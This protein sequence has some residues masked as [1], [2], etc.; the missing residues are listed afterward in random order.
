[1]TSDITYDNPDQQGDALELLLRVRV[2]GV[3]AEGVIAVGNLRIVPTPEEDAENRRRGAAFRAAV[4]WKDDED[5]GN[6][7]E[8]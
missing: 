1:M 2:N 5:D 4:G 8:S 6:E 3:I 7:S